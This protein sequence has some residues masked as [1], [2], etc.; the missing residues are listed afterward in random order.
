MMIVNKFFLEIIEKNYGV[1]K[2]KIKINRLKGKINN[3]SLADTPKFT[4]INSN[5]IS[6]KMI[7]FQLEMSKG[8]EKKE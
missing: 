4:H 5:I 1:L 3:K 8:Q 7:E 2:E 6:Q